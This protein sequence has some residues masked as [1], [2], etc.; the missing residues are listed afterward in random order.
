[1]RQIDVED[2]ILNYDPEFPQARFMLARSGAPRDGFR[3]PSR[4]PEASKP[5]AMPNDP[6][7]SPTDDFSRF[8]GYDA[9]CG[10][11][12]LYDGCERNHKLGCYR[13]DVQR[14]S[15]NH[16]KEIKQKKYSNSDGS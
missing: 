1:M 13:Q 16:G 9:V 12:G 4:W 7:P 15:R 2:I 6:A 5:V 14:R 8:N 11:R 3:V 10:T